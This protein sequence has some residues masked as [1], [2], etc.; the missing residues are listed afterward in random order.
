MYVIKQRVIISSERDKTEQLS[1]LQ[2]HTFAF[3]HAF[4]NFLMSY[5]RIILY[6]LVTRYGPQSVASAT[7]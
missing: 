4:R 7:S 3:N 5:R 1:E 2:L 6:G